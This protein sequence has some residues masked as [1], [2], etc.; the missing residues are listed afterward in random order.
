[1]GVA[2]GHKLPGDPEFITPQMRYSR[3]DA[4]TLDSLEIASVVLYRT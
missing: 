3:C 4:E 1:L 2:V